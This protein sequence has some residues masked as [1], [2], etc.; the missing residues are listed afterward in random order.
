MQHLMPEM[1]PRQIASASMASRQSSSASMA[2][3]FLATAQIAI[4]NIISTI[5]THFKYNQGSELYESGINYNYSN[6]NG[7]MQSRQIA[8]ASMKG[9]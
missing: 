4:R 3:R 6:S 9:R 7:G 8:S 1:Q 2:T 5:T